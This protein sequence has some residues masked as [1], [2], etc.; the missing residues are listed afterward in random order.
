MLTLRLLPEEELDGD[1]AQCVELAV[2]R[3]GGDTI[4]VTSLRLTPSDLVRL[5]TEA[6]LALG[7]I[8][9]EVLRAEATWRQLLG[10]WFEEGRAAVDSLTPDVALLTRVLEGL[11]TSL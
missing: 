3:R 11:R 1:P 8:R 7:E 5:R 6:D 10:R 4:T 9:A 2:P